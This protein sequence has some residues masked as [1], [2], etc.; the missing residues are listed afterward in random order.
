MRRAVTPIL[1]SFQTEIDSLLRRS[2]AAEK[3][4]FDIYRHL[5]ELPGKST[6][7]PRTHS[8]LSSIDPVPALEYAQNLQKRAEKVSDLEVENQKLRETLG[9]QRALFAQIA[10][11]LFP[12][13]YNHEF[14]DV[15]NQGKLPLWPSWS[16]VSRALLVEVTIKQLREKIKDLEDR[17]ESSIQVGWH[18]ASTSTSPFSL[19]S[20]NVS[21]RK[22]KNS[23][24]CSVGRTS[25]L[26]LLLTDKTIV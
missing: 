2:K 1:R 6:A 12:D 5:R 25:L 22:R 17:T 3:A 7:S 4:F 16:H 26:L 10:G 18:R 14:A 19:H 8:L 13:E 9:K 21:K 11:L 23:N 24:V 20:S 15:K